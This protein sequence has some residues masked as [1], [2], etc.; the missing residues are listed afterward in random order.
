MSALC[1]LV[2]FSIGQLA[3]E[4]QT[5]ATRIK[6]LEAKVASLDRKLQMASIFSYI[7]LMSEFVF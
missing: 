2:F 6:D 7:Y 3:D 5:D 4:T 1:C